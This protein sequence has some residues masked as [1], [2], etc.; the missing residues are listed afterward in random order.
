[1]KYEGVSGDFHLVLRGENYKS[2]H[3]GF[4][5]AVYL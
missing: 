1:M 2:K 4:I 3:E 5:D